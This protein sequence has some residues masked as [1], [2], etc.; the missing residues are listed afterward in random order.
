MYSLQDSGATDSRFIQLWSIKILLKI[1]TFVWLVL[2]RRVLT[3]DILLKRD[4]NEPRSYVLCSGTEE[5]ADHLFVTCYFFRFLLE[6]LLTNKREAHNCVAVDK[7]WEAN[8]LKQKAFWR[9]KLTTIALTRWSIW[10]EQ[11]GRRFE[12]KKQSLKGW[13]EQNG[14][15]FENK[16]QSLKGLL[17]VIR[18]THTDWIAFCA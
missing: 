5:N 4:W 11:N 12:N 3:V 2:R 15:R 7:L 6:S 13:L 9:R 16:K 17:A 8:K 14:R 18:S 1:K 10:L